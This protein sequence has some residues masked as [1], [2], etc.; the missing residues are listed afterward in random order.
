MSA[1]GLITEYNPFHN[2]H[3][4]H[5]RESL[6]V[7]GAEV[8]VA[9]M[10]GHFLQRGEPALVDK[11]VRTAMALAAGVDVVVELPFP[12]ACNSAPDFAAGAVRA[13]DAL[14]GIDTLCFGSETG[15]LAPL[16]QLATW[17]EEQGA[18]VASGTA[19]LL[20]DGLNYPTA[21]ARLAAAQ[22][23]AGNAELLATPNNILAIEY[24][25]ALRRSGSPLQPFTI[26]RRGAGYHAVGAVDGIASATGIRA[27]LAE[28]RPVASYLPAASLAELQSAIAAGQNTDPDKLYALLLARLIQDP[29]GLAA[30]WQWLPG[31]ENRL[32]ELAD[33]AGSYAEL[34]EQAN[35]RHLTRTRLQRLLIYLLMQ[36][37][38]AEMADHLGF[39][40]AYLHLLG[41]SRRGQAWLAA[42]RKRR[43]LPLVANYSRI[44]SV[45]KRHHGAGSSAHGL[46]HR[47]LVLENRATRL[48]TLLMRA[49]QGS[50][51]NRDYYQPLLS[52]P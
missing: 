30:T 9:V 12:W 25:R 37:S 44:Q 1:V 18:A 43:H 48:Y 41:T 21:R 26:P 33:T 4:H 24:L 6:R 20:R 45:L 14:G 13:L 36:V 15:E 38:T 49:W 23:P 3:L 46:A 47:Q 32:I 42:T 29:S 19:A 39:G 8:S 10:S 34:V 11:W 17:L 16:V 50:S 22:G 52:G 5:L 7:T 31:L 40:P 28:G 2:G 35:S 51:R 27:M